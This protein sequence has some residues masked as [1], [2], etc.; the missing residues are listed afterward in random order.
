MPVVS[1]RPQQE[2][3][4][5]KFLQTI[6]IAAGI[7][8]RVADF[9]QNRKQMGIQ[10]EQLGIQGEQLELQQGQEADND[11][12]RVLAMG[13]NAGEAGRNANLATLAAQG[14]EID[15][16]IS[17]AAITLG[18]IADPVLR[19]QVRDSVAQ[20]IGRDPEEIQDRF[21]L[22]PDVLASEAER[23][24]SGALGNVRDFRRL[25]AQGK[26]GP[27]GDAA[28]RVGE[29]GM[30]SLVPG[31]SI[32]TFERNEAIQN[33]INELLRVEIDPET[34]D[35]TLDGAALNNAG[36]TLDIL[37]QM[38]GEDGLPKEFDPRHF[39]L[40]GPNRVVSGPVWNTMAENAFQALWMSDENAR[41]MHRSSARELV[42]E[43][44]IPFG[45]AMALVEG[46]FQDV[47]VGNAE[48][49][50]AFRRFNRG[51]VEFVGNMD[52]INQDF[53][54]LGKTLAQDWN[55]PSDQI[56]DAMSMMSEFLHEKNP[57]FPIIKN[58]G[59]LQSMLGVVLGG[60]TGTQII[61]GAEVGSSVNTPT[62]NPSITGTR[63]MD[64]DTPEARAGR[65]GQPAPTP[66]EET[67]TEQRA[68]MRAY[69]QYAEALRSMAPEERAAVAEQAVGLHPF[70][71]PDTG[72][73]HY[74]ALTQE[75]VQEIL[76]QIEN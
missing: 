8:G 75:M 16:K 23:D 62:T 41:E 50:D 34:G 76:N 15:P 40:R 24:I 33:Q 52:P 63:G 26:L 60:P 28:A 5:Q 57:G 47:T 7:G 14:Q 56:I 51:M 2:D 58:M 68:M 38:A 69:S 44:G 39:G 21:I 20:L 9:V 42:D 37:L 43:F 55:L 17:L 46:R 4:F 12:S 48:F 31:S 65:T 18:D 25:T 45:D 10:E 13:L 1:R 54:N 64:L 6:N 35:Y 72:E 29:T 53:V 61:P 66:G 30:L 67:T 27:G 59:L 49:M 70:T 73:T 11:A 19:N 74:L 71:D 32:Q 3:G 22:S 36:P